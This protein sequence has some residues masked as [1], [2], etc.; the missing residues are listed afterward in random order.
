MQNEKFFKNEFQLP[1][2]Y[3]TYFFHCLILTKHFF[4]KKLSYSYFESMADQ[5]LQYHYK[6]HP[7]GFIV[8]FLTCLLFL[9]KFKKWKWV[10]GVNTLVTQKYVFQI[11]KKHFSASRNE[12]LNI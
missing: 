3:K 10:N 1:T 6:I 5:N 7:N 8:T 2:L 12:T 4:T 11:N 9:F